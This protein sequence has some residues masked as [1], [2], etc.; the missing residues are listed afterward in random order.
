MPERDGTAVGVDDLHV[1]VVL[2]LPRQ[3]HRGEGLVDLHGIDVV[4]R[5]FGPLEHGGRGRDRAGEH[6]DRVH[7][8]QRE[9]V[10]A[11]PGAQAQRIGLLLAHDQDGGSPVGDLGGVA[12]GDLATLG[13]E[14]GLEVGQRLHCAVGTDPLIGGDQLVG[15]LSLVV[16]DGDGDDLVL[17]PSLGRRPG[18]PLVAPGREGVEVFPRDA[19]L[20]GD[21]L[22]PYALTDQPAL[23]GVAGH[24]AGP[25]GEAQLTDDRGAHGGAGH[26]LD[27]G[28]HDDVVGPGHDTLGREVQR[29]LGR[30]ALAVDGGGGHG[31]GPPG[32]QHGVAPDVQ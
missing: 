27:T 5:H 16:A 11:R 7:A 18:R 22:G 26:A 13:F 23:L 24:H 28:G 30:A 12:G 1:G 10:E 17:E 3:H 14:G 31:L 20:V 9:G 32:G 29:L 21:H 15:V 6:G 25:E 2:L 8:G 19:P 4:H